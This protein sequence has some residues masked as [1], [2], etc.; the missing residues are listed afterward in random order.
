MSL[1]SRLTWLV[2]RR[3]SWTLQGVGIIECIN[4]RG[5]VGGFNTRNGVSGANGDNSVEVYSSGNNIDRRNMV[6][7]Y[8]GFNRGSSV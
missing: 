8:S 3:D 1:R 5:K 4:R 7:S 2:D 6:E